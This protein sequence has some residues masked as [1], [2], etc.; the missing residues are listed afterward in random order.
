MGYFKTL[1]LKTLSIVLVSLAL[2]GVVY[3]SLSNKPYIV[4]LSFAVTFT[5][6]LFWANTKHWRYIVKLIRKD[7]VAQRLDD[8]GHLV[9]KDGNDYNLEHSSLLQWFVPAAETAIAYIFFIVVIVSGIHAYIQGPSVLP[10]IGAA[11]KVY[12]DTILRSAALIL[13]VDAVLHVCI[14][15]SSPGIDE[16]VDALALS[17]SGIFILVTNRLKE[18]ML[19]IQGEGTQPFG[20]QDAQSI[21]M[22]VAAVMTIFLGRALIKKWEKHER[23]D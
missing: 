19:D 9:P 20:V 6:G 23:H 2:A 10:D 13:F 5:I 8:R 11:W 7:F 17:L 21:L 4:V 16:M 15:I 3:A 1:G 22:L 12:L 14:L 18:H